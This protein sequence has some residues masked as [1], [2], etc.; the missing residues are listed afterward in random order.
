MEATKLQM[1]KKRRQGQIK[2]LKASGGA[3]KE[4]ARLDTKRH[5]RQSRGAQRV[6]ELREVAASLHADSE[7][8]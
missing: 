3:S 5:R 4:I 6:H 7:L 2:Q 8:R 1:S